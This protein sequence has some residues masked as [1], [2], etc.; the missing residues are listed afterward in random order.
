MEILMVITFQVCSMLKKMCQKF[1]QDQ[2]GLKFEQQ[3]KTW[4]SLSESF[5]GWNWLSLNNKIPKSSPMLKLK[6]HFVLQN[7]RTCDLASITTHKQYI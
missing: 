3:N 6:W 5:C 1:Q 2:K 4:L 7:N